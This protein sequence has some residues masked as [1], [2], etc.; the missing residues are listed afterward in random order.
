[1][2]IYQVAQQ[3]GVGSKDLVDLL[4]ANGVDV[5]GPASVLDDATMTLVG[6]LLSQGAAEAAAPPVAEEIAEPAEPAPIPT[7]GGKVTAIQAV[8]TAGKTKGGEPAVESAP[9]PAEPVVEVAAPPIEVEVAAPPPEMVEPAPAKVKGKPAKAKPAAPEPA[10]EAAAETPPPAPEPPPI[11]EPV[12][13]V[14]PGAAQSLHAAIANRNGARPPSSAGSGPNAPRRPE[15]GPPRR[16]GLSGLAPPPA[17]LPRRPAGPPGQ[18]PIRPGQPGQPASQRPIKSYQEL[19]QDIQ[20]R[21][22][23]GGGKATPSNKMGELLAKKRGA[24]GAPVEDDSK[25]VKKPGAKLGIGDREGRRDKRHQRP[26]SNQIDGDDG[27]YR[28]RKRRGDHKQAHRI[29]ITGPVELVP[30]I[31]IRSFSEATGIRAVDIQ[32]KLMAELKVLATINAGISEEHAQLLALEYGI[33]LVIGGRKSKEEEEIIKVEAQDDPNDLVDRPPIVTFMGHVDHGKTSLMD[34]IRNE[35]VAAG[36]AGGITQHIGAYR[37]TKDD[38]KTVTFLDTPGHQAFTA[39]R[40]RGANM[41]DIVVLVVAADDGVMPQTE[42][43][44]N[45]A[46]AAKDTTIVVAVNK[47]DLPGANQER[48]LQQLSKFSLIPEAW[49]GETIVIPTSAVTGLGL[50]QLLESLSLVAELKDWKANPKRPG[51]GNVVEATM[52]PDSGVKATLLVRNG[53]LRRG[54]VLLCG[55]AFGRIRAMFDDKGVQLEEAGPS[56]PVVVFGLDEVP[57]AGDS[58]MAIDDLSRAREIAEQRKGRMREANR[59][60]DQIRTLETIFEKRAQEL[61]LIVKA[62]VRGSIEALRKEIGQFAHAEVKVKI[63]RDAVGAITESDVVLADAS[64]AIIIGFNVIAESKAESLAQDKGIEIRRYDIIYQVLD[65]IK[66]ALEGLLKPVSREVNL[67]RAVV[68]KIFPISR[69]GTIAGCRVTQGTIERN[70][71]LRVIRDGV[72]IGQ[73]PLDSLK[74]VKDDAR[75]VREGF[76]CGIKLAGF[77]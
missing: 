42:E 3:W 7:K 8:K 35:K 23:G 39:M 74:R 44:I 72:V 67:G 69:V 57:D 73:Y 51:Q 5:K 52:D 1:M 13:A 61:N 2:R 34:R 38:G 59:A 71:K 15:S 27:E 55:A 54:D 32:K 43:A 26:H 47:S 17:S 31:T 18:Q 14:P 22:P 4:K 45:H 19:L 29:N 36:E 24:P 60:P 53:T 10:K 66:K 41:T 46:Q 25:G 64:N 77:D 12:R 11:P 37:V 68:L 49:G 63:I 30:P 48:V 40:A 76:E 21:S 16:T 6:R 9:L 50:P 28:H 62:D 33:E 75:E 58:F 65:D 20:N 56:T 70:A